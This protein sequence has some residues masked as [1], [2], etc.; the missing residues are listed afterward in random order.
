MSNDEWMTAGVSGISYGILRRMIQA[1]SALLLRWACRLSTN[2]LPGELYKSRLVAFNLL[3]EAIKAGGGKNGIHFVPSAHTRG[4]ASTSLRWWPLHLYG[5]PVL[6]SCAFYRHILLI[7]RAAAVLFLR[8]MD[9]VFCCLYRSWTLPYCR[10]GYCH[11]AVCAGGTPYSAG[12]AFKTSLYSAILCLQVSADLLW[13]MLR[14]NWIHLAGD[15]GVYVDF[16]GTIFMIY[17]TFWPA[18]RP[19]SA[20]STSV[21]L[22]HLPVCSLPFYA[23][24]RCF[25][26]T[27][28]TVV[29]FYS[30]P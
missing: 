4:V 13:A 25:M 17:T 28:W 23:F 14:L 29:R 24:L 16:S 20:G 7:G 6:V 5:L 3:E 2:C 11:G 21:T 30:L 1:S 22:P 12:V 19:C 18:S 9:I 26:R 27:G 15:N 10:K 8:F